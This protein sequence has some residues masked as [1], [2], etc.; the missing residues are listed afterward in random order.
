MSGM[1]TPAQPAQPAQHLAETLVDRLLAAD[2]FTGTALGLREYDAL[3]PDPSRAA[4]Q[5][6]AAD[7]EAIA[8][9]AE[10][11]VTDDPAGAIT[12]DVV[13]TTCANQLTALSV[14]AVEYTVS[15]MPLGSAPALFAVLARSVL[16]DPAAAADYLARVKAAGDW[17]DGTTARLAGGAARGRYPVRSLLEAAVAWTERALAEPVPPA[18]LAPAPPAGW[19]GA[20]AWRDEVAE[21]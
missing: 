9:E 5:E 21:V 18:V 16:A 14:R 1:E 8:R 17:L 19:D 20:A 13:R 4:E 3:L 15:A 2:P 12:R 7:L 10:E 11:L 6:L